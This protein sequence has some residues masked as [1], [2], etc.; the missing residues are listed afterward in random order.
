MA[1]TVLVT[2]AVGLTF[3]PGLLAL[4]GPVA[5]WPSVGRGEHDPRRRLWRLVTA[6]PVAAVLSVATS[7]GL[8]LLCAGLLQTRLGFSL[9]RGQPHGAEVKVAQQAAEQGFTSGIVAPTEVL[10]ES[11]GLARKLPGL[12]R[13]ERAVGSTRGVARVLGS[14]TRPKRTL[15]VFLAKD[16][17]TARFLIVL[18]DEPL[19]ATAIAT[20]NRIRDRLPA[21]LHGS[22]L[23]GAHVSY[24]GDTALAEETVASIRHDGVRVG[25]AVLLVNLVLLA[26]FLRRI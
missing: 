11:S 8:I 21:L 1:L 7:T 19:D 16:G 18:R 15:P 5:F 25:L 24:A 9:V 23:A 4:L 10:V 22:P 26:I 12:G 2:L 20:F 6:R 13:L 14:T 17:L 3:F